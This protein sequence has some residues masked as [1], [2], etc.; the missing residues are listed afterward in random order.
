MAR[1]HN[2]FRSRGFTLTEVMASVAIITIVAVGT[3]GYQYHNIKF[4]RASQAQITGTRI[5]QLLLEDWKSKGG[6]STYDPTSLGLGFATTS[7]GNYVITLDRQT[8]YIQ[9]Q[10][11]QIDQDT[12]A[13]VTLCQVRVVVRWRVDYAPGAISADDPQITLTTYVRRDQD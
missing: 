3:M 1:E 8:F 4:S 5:G 11:N 12:V 2:T 13:G 7:P 9:P 6:D 10:F